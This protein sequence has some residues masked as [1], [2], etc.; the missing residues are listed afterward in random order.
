LLPNGH[1]LVTGGLDGD[2]LASCEL[3][4]PARGD[5]T[6]TSDLAVARYVHTAT[7]LPNGEVLVA[8]GLSLCCFG[9]T[10]TAEVYNVGLGFSRDWQPEI[11]AATLV[12]GNRLWLTGS[13]F[14]GI[15]QASGGNY[16]DSSTNYPVMQLRSIDN[17]EVTF[18][19]ADPVRGWA[20]GNFLSSPLSD[21]PFGPALVTVFTNG[22]PSSAE[23]LVVGQR[24]QE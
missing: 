10:A 6:R 16:Q 24:A 3:Y 4:D 23:Y 7:L 11:N 9:D 19:L 20:D 12:A 1:V 13:R 8:G 5:W 21:F 2:A 15:S 14:Q 22:I 18:L 17:N